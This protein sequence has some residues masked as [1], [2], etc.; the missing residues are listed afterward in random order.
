MTIKD[1]LVHIDSSKRHAQRVQIALDLARQHGAHLLGLYVVSLSDVPDFIPGHSVHRQTAG[2]EAEA[3]RISAWFEQ[4]AGEAGVSAEWCQVEPHGLAPVDVTAELVARSHSAD[5][6]I[7]GQHDP[8]SGDAG[9]PADLA[10]SAVL[11]SGRPVLVI[12]YTGAFDFSQ[13]RA[14]LAWNAGR[15]AVRAINDAM[16]LLKNAAKTVLVVAEDQGGGGSD[17]IP[18]GPIC[19]H[20]A[21]HGVSAE[22]QHVGAA[23]SPVGDI[24]LSRAA[25][26]G[27]NL[28]VAGAYQHS[29]VRELVLGGVTRQF[30]EQMT[31]PVL[32]SR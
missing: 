3:G 10:E 6:V 14:I 28:I 16:P 11:E 23:G 20:L 31:V 32:M 9:I 8:D 13:V 24:L 26:E 12:P 29:R 4:C 17:E 27:A 22:V 15:E 25:D 18:C 7:V 19:A 5:L 2:A 30:L 1:I 21:R